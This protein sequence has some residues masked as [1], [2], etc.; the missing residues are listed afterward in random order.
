MPDIIQSHILRPN[1][2]EELE[3]SKANNTIK[4]VLCPQAACRG[5]ASMTAFREPPSPIRQIYTST[6]LSSHPLSVPD[7][8][9]GTYAGIPSLAR[10][11]NN[12]VIPPKK[13]DSRPKLTHGP[14]ASNR[15][16]HDASLSAPVSSSSHGHRVHL[17]RSRSNCRGPLLPHRQLGS[18]SLF[19]C[20]TSVR[21]TAS[22]ASS[23]FSYRGDRDALARGCGWL[24]PP[25]SSHPSSEYPD[26]SAHAVTCT[27]VISGAIVYQLLHPTLRLALP[28]PFTMSSLSYHRSM[29]CER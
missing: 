12:N 23:R 4:E 24:I 21:L 9:A 3:I 7:K 25:V 22:N 13:V 15:C 14:S 8:M 19:R 5:S 28:S 20:A 11:P 10:V 17:R 26:K 2:C 1:L 6:S 16:G 18:Y 27:S 29:P